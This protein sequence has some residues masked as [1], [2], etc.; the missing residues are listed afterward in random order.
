M[1]H[2]HI[3]GIAG[4]FMGGLARLALEL[5]YSVSGCDQ[6]I[7]PP[8]NDQLTELGVKVV[9]NF[10]AEQLSLQPDL[11]IIG[12]VAKRGMP[13]IE[14]I[15]NQHLPYVSGPEWLYHHILKDRKVLAVAGTHGKTTTASMLT[16]ILD[17]AGFSPS[18]LIGGIPENFQVSSRLT[19]S[20]YFVIEADEYDTAF[21]DKRSKFVHYHPDILII[22]NLEYDHADIFPDL[23]AIQKQFH[24]L[25][26]TICGHG[27]IIYNATQT[28]VKEVLEMGLWTPTLSFASTNGYHTNSSSTDNH[29]PV[30]WQQQLLG[31]VQWDLLAQYNQLNALAAI[32]AA[33]QIGI[34]EQISINALHRFRNVK[35]RLQCKGKVAGITLY[36]DFAHHPTAISQTIKALKSKQKDQGRLLVII[37]P[38]SNTMKLGVMKHTLVL[39]LQDANLIFIDAQKTPWDVKTTFS[40]LS[41]QTIIVNGIEQLTHKVLQEAKAKDVIVVM[42]NSESQNIH[43]LLL[44]GLKAKALVQ[45]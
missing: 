32:A 20:N 10:S 31:E 28:S 40:T 26:R 39:A 36:D 2:I 34:E 29:F 43:D 21:F 12:N 4:T 14:A 3:I 18:F 30:Y 23:A 45:S 1:K 24:H 15:L 9:P 11:Y 33:K 25:I 44:E 27:M 8:M 38:R 5:G 37:E 16:W 6:H 41:K 42:S 35:R 17:Y 7:Y 19:S 13:V 22:N